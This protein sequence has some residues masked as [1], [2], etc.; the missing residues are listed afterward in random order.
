MAVR[1][2]SGPFLVDRILLLLITSLGIRNYITT[3]ASSQIFI[4]HPSLN[5]RLQLCPKISDVKHCLVDNC[6]LSMYVRFAVPSESI[7]RRSRIHYK[8]LCNTDLT[9]RALGP[10]A[11]C[12]NA[13]C[14]GKPNRVVRRIG[15]RLI[16]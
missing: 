4:T 1:T 2:P 15:C 14:I 8:K 3:F 16:D 12:D 11:F 5:L 9:N 7:Y 6:W 10:N 13:S